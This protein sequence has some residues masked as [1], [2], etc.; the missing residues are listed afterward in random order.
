[1]IQ[2]RSRLLCGCDNDTY[3]S[4]IIDNNMPVFQDVPSQE[5]CQIYTC[6]LHTM[7]ICFSGTGRVHIKR[8]I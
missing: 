8:N 3:M 7:Y 6:F 2:A 5:S 4:Y 1:V